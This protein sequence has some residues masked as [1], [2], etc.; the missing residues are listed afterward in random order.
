MLVSNQGAFQT[1]VG[2][3][4]VL[5]LTSLSP[6]MIKKEADSDNIKI[7]CPFYIICKLFFIWNL[8]F[9]VFQ[10]IFFFF[11][12]GGGCSILNTPSKF[13]LLRQKG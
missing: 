5:L 3:N 6:Q 8:T 12:W 1:K 7:K 9:I 11:F 13:V 2:P 4:I 10:A